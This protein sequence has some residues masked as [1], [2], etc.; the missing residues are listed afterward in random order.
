MKRG[1]PRLS[2]VVFVCIAACL[3]LL[4]CDDD[5]PVSSTPDSPQAQPYEVHIE[6]T[7][8]TLQ[9][10][11]EYVDVTVTKDSEAMWGF[12][13]LLAYDATALSFQ[14]ATPGTIYDSCGWEYFTFRNGAN[15]NCDSTCP[16]GLLRVVGIAETNNGANHPACFLTDTPFTLTTLDFLVSDD[17]TFEC[18][19]LPIRFFWLDCGDN[20]ITYLEAADLVDPYSQI[21]AISRFVYEFEGGASIAQDGA[22]TTYLG[23]PNSCLED[24]DVPV[25][26]V[27]FY[28]GGINTICED[29]IDLRGDLN[30]NGIPYEISDAV[31]YSNY[32]VFGP[33]V[34][35]SL[36]AQTFASDVNADGIPLSV[37]DLVCLIRVI[38]G[39][40]LP[41]PP[42]DTVAA[43]VSYFGSIIT[44]NEDM[45]AAYVVVEGNVVPELLINGVEMKYAYDAAEDVTRVLVVGFEQN[46]AIN[47][48]F[49]AANGTIVSTEMATYDGAPVQTELTP[50][51]FV[52]NQN[53]PDPFSTTTTISFAV[54]EQT[55]Y[56][57]TIIN[58]LGQILD[59]VHGSTEAGTVSI[60]W[61]AGNNPDGPYF[62]R[63]EAGPYRATKTMTLQRGG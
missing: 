30:Y 39:D 29:T 58:T 11:H 47:G 20:S 43:T 54:P 1:L 2:G 62:Y 40:A 36:E 10:E 8:N 21:V 12:D 31:L 52:L 14:N 13:I 4:G 46:A 59:V 57:L 63:V 19:P 53:Y 18:T 33:A 28:N 5:S 27:D 22:F 9:G 16:S 26:F 25:R 38:T 48:T 42:L 50:I 23:A 56:T 32:F 45:G 60:E 44:V 6:Q 35:D 55:N 15:G 17:S 61:N 24:P 51:G 3:L 49:L 41:N 7:Q 34:F 37:A